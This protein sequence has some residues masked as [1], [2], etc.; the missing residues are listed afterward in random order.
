M[1]LNKIKEKLQVLEAPRGGASS[2]FKWSPQPGQKYQIRM[3]PYLHNKD[4]PFSELHFYY[5]LKKAT[6][7][8]PITFGKADPVQEFVDSLKSTGDKEDWKTAVALQAKP[9]TYIPIL[10]RGKE[11]E[12]VKFWGF[13]KQIYQELLKVIDDPDYGDISDPKTGRDITVEAVKTEKPWP[14]IMIRVKPNTS[15]M[16]NDKEVLEAIKEM[17]KLDSLWP[18]PTYDELKVML[19]NYLNNIDSDTAAA[20]A[21]ESAGTVEDQFAKANEN[22]DDLPTV[23]PKTKAKP[24][25]KETAKIDSAEFDDLFN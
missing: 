21:A 6:I 20:P 24:A 3:L 15:V 16:T 14:D 9:R 18:E 13:G 7:L 12:G 1:D 5:S 2:K 10:V 4:W 25:V 19:E 23:A 17:P 8:S 11:E 22:F